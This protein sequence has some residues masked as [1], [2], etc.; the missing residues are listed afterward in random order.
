MFV[1][2]FFSKGLR[3]VVEVRC[4]FFFSCESYANETETQ[5]EN[6]R[7]EVGT[8]SRTQMRAKQPMKYSKYSLLGLDSGISRK[9]EAK[10]IFTEIA[11]C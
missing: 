3:W 4:R 8:F 11:K 6:C 1:G 5:F 2:F 7:G 9:G 10:V